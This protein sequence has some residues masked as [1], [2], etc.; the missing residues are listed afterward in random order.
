M[1]STY[2]QVGNADTDSYYDYIGTV[3]YWWSHSL[4]SDQTYNLLLKTCNFNFKNTSQDCQDA[5]RRSDQEIGD[6]NQYNIYTENCKASQQKHKHSLRHRSF[7]QDQESSGFDPCTE[8]YAEIYYN[9]PDVQKTLHANTT[10]IPY[11]WT[12]CRYLFKTI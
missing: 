2:V 4:I 8:N 7:F 6:I 1:V 11:K 5:L 3:T 12:A 10:G 9:R